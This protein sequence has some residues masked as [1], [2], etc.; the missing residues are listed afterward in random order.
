M[1]RIN[2]KYII[3]DGYNFINYDAGL[4]KRMATSLESARV[5]LNDMLSEFVAYSGEIGIV[6]YDAM[7]SD[8]LK[9]KVEKYHNIDVV[10]TK[11][12]ETADAYIERLV[13]KLAVDKTNFIRVVTLDWAQ[14]QL[15]LGRGAVR[16]S[17]SEWSR[18]IA[19]MR[20]GL[21]E[22]NDREVK[23]HDRQ[24]GSS[25][26]SETLGKLESLLKNNDK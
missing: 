22:F 26:D 14:Q 19:K 4:R 12:K 10:Y 2:K 6:V 1:F 17:G 5:H 15:V 3:I 18:E 13:D 7:G 11:Q 8:G 23:K 20:T 21:S 25:L 24:L 16:V 9:S